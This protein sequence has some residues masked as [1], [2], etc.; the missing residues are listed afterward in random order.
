V[1]H[2]ITPLQKSIL[3]Q[4]EKLHDVKIECFSEIK[5]MVDKVKMVEKHLELVSRTYQRMRIL[6]SKIEDLEE[7][8]N[9]EKNVPSSLPVIKSYDINVH[10][11][12]TTECQELA[13]R[14][15]ENDTND[16][17]GMMEFNEKSIYDIQRYIQWLEINFEDEHPVPY[18]L[19]QKLEDS[20][21]NINEEL[22]A[23]EVI[24]KDDIQ[25]LLVKPLMEYSHYISFVHKFVI[26]MEE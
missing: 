19:F 25:E 22:Q 11:F 13:S 2:D 20:H 24:S 15:K 3:E 4:Q 10:T 7:W 1:D 21:E 9:K 5:K 14:F 12:A 23:K 26:R 18:A 6:Q 17:A 8:R 16:L